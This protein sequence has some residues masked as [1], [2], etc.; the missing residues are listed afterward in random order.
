MR[1]PAR[2]LTAVRV[3]IERMER[4]PVVFGHAQVQFFENDVIMRGEHDLN[5]ATLQLQ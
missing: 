1:S 5:A 4:Y 2:Y 3:S